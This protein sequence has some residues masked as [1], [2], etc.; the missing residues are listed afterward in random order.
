MQSTQL[1]LASNK[2]DKTLERELVE[3]LAVLISFSG[4]LYGIRG[5]KY[6][7][8]RKCVEELMA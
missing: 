4:K 6:E 5:Y 2:E 1:L 7:R 3:D 8:V